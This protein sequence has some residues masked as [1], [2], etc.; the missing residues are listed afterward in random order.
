MAARIDTEMVIK[1]QCSLRMLRVSI[2]GTVLMVG[3][4]MRMVLNATMPC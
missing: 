3:G 4:I 1:I 2:D